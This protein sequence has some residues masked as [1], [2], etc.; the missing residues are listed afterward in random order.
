MRILARSFCAYVPVERFHNRYTCRDNAEIDF[1]HSGERVGH[2]SP[3]P[4]HRLDRAGQS[5]TYNADSGR[6]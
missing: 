4:I 5:G 2:S 3:R 1:E 6:A